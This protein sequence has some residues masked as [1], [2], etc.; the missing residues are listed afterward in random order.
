VAVRHLWRLQVQRPRL[1]H[2]EALVVHGPLDLD[3]Q[4]DHVFGAP[5]QASEL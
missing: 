2:R 1:Q 3:R 5:H 4:A